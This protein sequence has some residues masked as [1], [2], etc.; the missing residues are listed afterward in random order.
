MCQDPGLSGGRLPGPDCGVAAV[1]LARERLRPPTEPRGRLGHHCC[2]LGQALTHSP[3]WTLPSCPMDNAAGPILPVI[4][5]VIDLLGSFAKFVKLLKSL[6]PWKPQKV[7]CRAAFVCLSETN[8]AAK[9]IIQIMYWV[10]S[11]RNEQMAGRRF[12]Y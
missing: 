5:E 9:C 6:K 4:C 3:N 8:G 1:L 7:D 2:L 10:R 11:D 12:R